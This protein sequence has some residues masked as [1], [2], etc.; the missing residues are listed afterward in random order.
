M[1]NTSRFKKQALAN[2]IV[3]ACVIA[4]G[5]LYAKDKVQM[6]VLYPFSEMRRIA[7][8]PMIDS[9]SDKKAKLDIAKLQKNIIGVL[10]ARGYEPV[11][12]DEGVDLLQGLTEEDFKKADAN[13]IKRIGPENERWIL[14]VC[15]SDYA[16]KFRIG[17]SVTA[18]VY[19]FL[20]DK[21]RV[22]I[23]WSDVGSG[24]GKGGI[25]DMSEAKDDAIWGAF[26]KMWE[27]FPRLPT[28]NK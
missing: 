11:A 25:L 7:V 13:M 8:L 24:A 14:V 26:R 2:L 12:S 10:A 20:F 21:Q 18:Q 23:A 27:A 17:L 22:R 15:M 9:R 19:G 1:S 4:G 16:S 3:A 28:P 6:P 5:S